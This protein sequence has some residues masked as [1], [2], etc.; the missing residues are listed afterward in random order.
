MQNIPYS[1]YEVPTS[2]QKLEELIVN[3]FAQLLELLHMVFYCLEIFHVIISIL[4]CIV[5]SK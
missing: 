3:L 4:G 2:A 5:D 1:L